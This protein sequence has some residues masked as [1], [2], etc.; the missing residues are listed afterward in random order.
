VNAVLGDRSVLRVGLGCMGMS[1]SYG[2]DTAS[3]D[4]AVVLDAAIGRGSAD[5]AI[6]L[7]TADVYGPFTN[8]ELVGKALRGRDRSGVLLAS[9]AGLVA[10]GEG[11]RTRVDARPEHLR[12]A[13]DASLL[14]L[15]VERL[16][17]HYLHRV[18]PAVPLEES[19]GALAGMISAGK[20]AALGLSEVGVGEL[21]RAQAIHPVAAVQSELSLFRRV[22]LHDVVPWCERNGTTFVAY[23]P[24]G[25]GWLTGTIDA[26][27][28]LGADDFRRRL[29]VF[30][31]DARRHNQPL[32]G[33]ARAI[34]DRHGVTV[35]QVAVAWLLAQSPQIIAIP[36]T[37]RVA[38]LTE[39]LAALALDLD[40]DEVA[41]LS[42]TPE[43]TQ[44]RYAEEPR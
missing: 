30:S 5:A 28:T 27:T 34:A 36:G 15:G 14:R 13:V 6:V 41:R 29:P 10:T 39:N 12:A 22:Q 16:D 20:V 24:L 9:K 21:D 23:A 42:N 44:P 31:A 33:Q 32:L 37:R 26:A 8:E 2:R 7:D 11:T 18:D 38:R 19:W 17:L 25:R 1:F 4:P 40:V 35:G 43:P 3:D